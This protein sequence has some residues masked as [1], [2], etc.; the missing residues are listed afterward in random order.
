MPDATLSGR[1]LAPG[2]QFFLFPNLDTFLIIQ[3]L[4]NLATVESWS[5]WTNSDKASQKRTRNYFMDNVFRCQIQEECSNLWL[6]KGDYLWCCVELRILITAFKN[7]TFFSM[8]WSGA[9]WYLLNTDHEEVLGWKLCSMCVLGFCSTIRVGS[10]NLLGFKQW[11]NQKI[12]LK[13]FVYVLL[14]M[15][16]VRSIFFNL[17][18]S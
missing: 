5:S 7:S 16:H 18:C 9:S 4:T 6:C 3:F 13:L 11:K 15:F 8:C 1:V 12:K 14:Y 17:D 10:Q 2:I